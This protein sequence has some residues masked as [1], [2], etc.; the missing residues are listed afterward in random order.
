MAT[1]A[2][3]GQKQE[4]AEEL[5]EARTLIEQAEYEAAL[6]LL[7]S[8]QEQAHVRGDGEVLGEVG[9]LAHAV[10]RRAQ[11]GSAATE[12]PD[13]PASVPQR[14]A[15]GTYSPDLDFDYDPMLVLLLGRFRARESLA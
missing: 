12:R 15:T 4:L 1:V 6:D 3:S 8:A 13:R 5:A 2:P 14:N 9:R 7:E 10:G 11:R